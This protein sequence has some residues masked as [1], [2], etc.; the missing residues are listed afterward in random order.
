MDREMFKE[1][2]VMAAVFGLVMAAA[3]GGA[4]C[5]TYATLRWECAAHGEMTGRTT[6]VKAMTC[7][8][9]VEPGRFLPYNETVYRNATRG[10]TQ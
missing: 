2:A 10:E 9:E 8:V 3:V 4:F 5:I 7:Y 6:E 1:L